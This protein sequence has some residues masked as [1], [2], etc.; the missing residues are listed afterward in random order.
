MGKAARAFKVG[1]KRRWE[2]EVEKV[3]DNLP[4]CNRDV[5]R[6]GYPVH[7]MAVGEKMCLD[8]CTFFAASIIGGDTRI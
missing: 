3:Q 5:S 2:M 8:H 6:E 7:T 1:G 4:A